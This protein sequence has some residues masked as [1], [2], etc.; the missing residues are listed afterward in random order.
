[1]HHITDQLQIILYCFIHNLHYECFFHFPFLVIGLA[2]M[3]II[4][5]L[6]SCFEGA[7][8]C[9]FLHSLAT[10]CAVQPLDF[11]NISR[12]RLLLIT[13]L[14]CISFI[15]NEV[16]HSLI[17]LRFFCFYLC[18]LLIYILF[19]IAPLFCNIAMS[20]LWYQLQIFF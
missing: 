18:E 9:F 3:T 13:D 14:I 1:M 17:C 11:C 16:K 20:L 12:K 15:V 4:N 7:Y 19:L 5:L 10:E 2:P 6:C 8:E